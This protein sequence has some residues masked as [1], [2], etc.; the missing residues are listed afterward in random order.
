LEPIT[1]GSLGTV[2]LI[3]PTPR[4][5]IG[6]TLAYLSCQRLTIP[7]GA[8]V[9]AYLDPSSEGYHEIITPDAGPSDAGDPEV[10]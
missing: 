7:A 5:V 10:P 9:S 2:T 4:R 6:H 3:L 8:I 1:G